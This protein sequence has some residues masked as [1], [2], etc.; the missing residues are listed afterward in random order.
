LAEQWPV[1]LSM[2]EKFVTRQFVYFLIVGW[3][4]AI[5]NF[6]SRILFNEYTSFSFAVMLS[7]I[8]GMI[9]AYIMSRFFVFSGS[10][11]N[12]IGRSILYFIVI[13][14]VAFLQTWVISL[15]MLAFVFPVVGFKTHPEMAAH[16][17]GIVFP[18]LTSYI[19][20]K[21]FSFG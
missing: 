9:A 4:A 21:R 2:I 14:A 6:I 20:Y 10:G 17:I 11:E 16:A 13:N 12:S 18:V 19:G 3:I 8:L 7:Y 1:S 15:S 5:I